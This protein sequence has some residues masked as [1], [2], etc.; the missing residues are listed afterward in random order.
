MNVVFDAG[1]VFA[2]AGW[3]KESYLCL[4]AMAKRRVFG[5]ATHNMLLELQGTVRRRRGDFP[6]PAGADNILEW[7]YGR[8][9][10]VEGDSLGKRRCRDLKDDIYLGCAL[11]VGS[12]AIITRD[13][14]LLA[15]EKPF[16]IPILTPRGLLNQLAHP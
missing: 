6:N 8:V 7:Y 3:R 9:K 13:Q 5:W 1:V 10:L 16:G 12:A 2:G 15:L 4:L 14:D 11:A